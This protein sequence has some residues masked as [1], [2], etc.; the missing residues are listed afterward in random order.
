MARLCLALALCA[1]CPAWAERGEA[2]RIGVLDFMGAEAALARWGA[3]GAALNAALPD[4]RFELVALD[5]PALETALAAGELDFVIT[6]PGHY[7]ALEYRHHISRIATAE[8]D[9]PVASTLVARA[10]L[11]G[12]EALAGQR[13]AIV[14][15]EAFGGFQVIWAEMARADTGLPGRVELVVTGFPMQAAADA[16]L[17]G[18][19]DVAVLRGCLLES[20]QA[21]D[22][23]RYGAL[24]PVAQRDSAGTGCAL[25]SPVYPGWPFAKTPT[26]PPDL[27]K[28]V[29]VAL[30]RMPAGN[31]W[32]VPLDY[33][34][35]HDLLRA[36][37]IGPY[38]RTGPVSLSE[39][40][41][42]YRDWLIAIAIALAFWALY[43]VRIE[44]LVRRRTRA[45]DTANAGL[46]REMAER[47]R[48]EEADRLHR[49]ELEHVARLSI[50]GE[51]ASS[52]AHELNQP[53]AA[54]S[55]YAQGVLMRV[56]VG[57]CAPADMERA[58]GE[59]AG[60]AD[61]A[62]LVIKRIRAFVRKRESLRA[63][64]SLAALLRETE[65]L[66]EGVL[67]RAGV[68]AEM[69]VEKD[70]P[71]VMA[72]RVQLQQVLLNLVQNAVD[73]M[74]DT[75]PDERRITLRCARFTDPKRGP[76]LCLSVRDRGCG[77]GPEAL[78]RFAEAFYTTKPEGIGLGLALSRSIVEAHGGWM[79]AETPEQGDGLR[80][81]VWLPER[82]ET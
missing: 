47:R 72:D 42:D 17:E 3:T 82:E 1:A 60:Q 67:R 18:S 34:P 11:G 6:N 81:L 53:L 21:A 78:E 73:A 28:E 26:T 23:A 79:R 56:K 68:A 58:A 37:R 12:L 69:Q 4:R 80:V 61:R 8:G 13:L 22:P 77:L 10:P 16:V 75:V 65:A 27:A 43:S 25:S 63:P 14:S 70:L 36:L 33:Q 30:M 48:A 39:F 40:I 64:V 50:L 59:I 74:E 52:I 51:M 71:D 20:L 46:K 45:L 29:A 2:L 31:L 9:D 49:R 55:N 44:T 62:A 54:I 41:A 15:P 32:T 57:N 38:A 5:I 19:A 35:V 7:A 66:Y 24:H 76:G